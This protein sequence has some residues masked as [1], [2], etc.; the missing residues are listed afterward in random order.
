MLKRI[1][2]IVVAGLWLLII[3]IPMLLIM[4]VL[5]CTGEHNVWFFQERVG[6]GGRLFKVFKFATMRENS[7]RIGSKD[8]TLNNDPRVL[9]V[10]RVL[11]KGK[12]NELPQ[13]INIIK[14]DMSLVGWRPLLPQGFSYY[15]REIQERIV[16]MK[17]GL[18]SL[19]SLI[20]RDEEAILDLADKEPRQVYIEDIAP[21][22]GRIEMYYKEHQSFWM[23][24]KIILLTPLVVFMPHSTIYLKAFPDLPK[25]EGLIA[26]YILGKD[27][28]AGEKGADQA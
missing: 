28:A 25:P 8:I 27:R 3:S 19:G 5:K 13:L 16:T 10:G 9:P 26:E 23:D 7:E 4:V 17:P 12:I 24:L 6:E 22:K 21:Y 18:T 15:P 2:D 11:R 20:F 1:F 14:G